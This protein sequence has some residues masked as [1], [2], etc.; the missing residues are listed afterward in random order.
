MNILITSIGSFSAKAT[1][2]SIRKNFNAYIYGCNSTQAE[3]IYTST[4]IDKFYCIPSSEKQTLYME[5]I[6]S[7]CT[8]HNIELLIPLTDAEI[9]ILNK[10]RNY[11]ESLGVILC[12]PS[13]NTIEHSRDKYKV[14]EFFKSDDFVKTINSFELTDIHISKTIFPLIAKPKTG[15]S[16]QGIVKINNPSEFELYLKCIEQNN[17]FVQEFITGD[18]WVADVVRQSSNEE[19]VVVTRKELTRTI[20]GAGI[21]VEI[22]QNIDIIS[23]TKK[24]VDKLNLNGCINIEFI[25][26]PKG[27]YLMDINPRFSAGVAFSNISGYDMVKNHLLCFM[28]MNIDKK[29]SFKKCIATRHYEETIMSDIQ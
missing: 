4:L 7:I 17:V 25:V 5:S 26:S 3:W 8:L 23:S 19:T 29:T 1:I 11:F 18:I 21:T 28:G 27:I 16:S 22:N 20:N 2:E 13:Q 15:R 9:D 6:L 24:I 14:Y 10:H 12:M